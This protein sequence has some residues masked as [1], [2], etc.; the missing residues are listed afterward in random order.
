MSTSMVST[1]LEIEREAE[2]ILT[3][4]TQ[5]VNRVMAEAKSQREA[6]TRASEDLIRKEVA[7][8]EAA[9]ASD[10][11][12]KVKELTAAG[13]KAMAVVKN[14]SDAAYEAGVQYIM[15]ALAEK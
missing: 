14:I 11:A 6:N 7:D 9:A 15:K 10:R 4:A 3:N 13:E 5:E 8:L 2:A 1:V 12:K